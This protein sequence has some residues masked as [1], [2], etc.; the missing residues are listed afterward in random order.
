MTISEIY[1]CYEVPSELSVY[2]STELDDRGYHKLSSIIDSDT[3]NTEMSIAAV[4]DENDPRD[5][6][7]SIRISSYHTKNEKTGRLYNVSI[8][9]FLDRDDLNKL[10]RFLGYIL[11]VGVVRDKNE[12]TP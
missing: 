5:G 11:K 10:Y 12:A 7:C 4:I 1:I 8:N 6:L 9:S 2:D 3:E